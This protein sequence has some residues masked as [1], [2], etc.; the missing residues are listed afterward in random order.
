MRF[1]YPFLLMFCIITVTLHAQDEQPV[2]LHIGD[3]APPLHLRA[4]LKGK[5]VQQFD[6][7]QVY[8]LEFW[9]TWC[10]PCKA[11]MPRLSVVAGKYRGKV[12][13]IG[14]DV[15][16]RETTSI[17]KIKA[18]VDSMG[19]RMDYQVAAEDSNFMAKT[20]LHAAGE[21]SIPHT[22]VVNQEGRLAWI[23]HPKDLDKVLPQI[24]SKTWDVEKALVERNTQNLLDSLD[25]EAHYGLLR[26]RS[27]YRKDSVAVP[28]SAL[29]AINEIVQ[30]QPELKYA[31][32][33]AY[34]T[35]SCLLQVN[36]QMACEYGRV[37]MVTPTYREPAYE[38]IVDA[39]DT[40]SGKLNLPPEIYQLGAVAAQTDIDQLPYPE[41]LALD[42]R[43]SKIAEWYTRANN[44]SKAIEAIQKAI[45]ALKSKKEFST[46]DLT[47]FE[48]RLQ[49]YRNL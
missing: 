32:R 23:G 42:K 34:E 14:I 44:K 36:P 7:G 30:K 10:V 3:P 20:W 31:Y 15:Y 38:A 25:M 1:S 12:T 28:D 11:A 45:E 17:R 41:I 40:Y 24:V 27:D 39:I 2:S 46:K 26:Y 13:I 22:I 37:A 4:W 35:F 16:E 19:N 33:V 8:I 18:F 43:Y 5:P 47:A 29:L 49:Q 6:K 9:A 48:S 21:R